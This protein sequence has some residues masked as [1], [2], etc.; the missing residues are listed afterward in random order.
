VQHFAKNKLIYFLQN[1]DKNK[2]QAITIRINKTI[3]FKTKI[4][5]VF[6][7]KSETICKDTT[8]FNMCNIFLKIN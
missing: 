4:S 8:L 6:L 3:H 2:P 1:N 5:I 7:I